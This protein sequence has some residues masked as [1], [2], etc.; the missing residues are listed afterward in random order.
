MPQWGQD[1]MSEAETQH[2]MAEQPGFHHGCW[3]LLLS[4]CQLFLGRVV[5]VCS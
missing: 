3:T 1:N 5:Q 4:V 2:N